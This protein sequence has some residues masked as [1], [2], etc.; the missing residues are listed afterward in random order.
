MLKCE[1]YTKI[2]KT[3]QQTHT[4]LIIERLDLLFT[5]RCKFL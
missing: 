1:K 3:V 4:C 2:S 5:F